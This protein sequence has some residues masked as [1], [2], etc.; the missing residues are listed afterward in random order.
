MCVFA[1][2]YLCVT[3]EPKENCLEGEKRPVRREG[4]RDKKA[5]GVEYNKVQ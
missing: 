3:C 1:H 2:V 4:K 5:M